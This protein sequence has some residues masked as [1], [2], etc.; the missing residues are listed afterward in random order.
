MA[1]QPRRIEPSAAYVKVRVSG[2]TH[3]VADAL[4][5]LHDAS[6]TEGFEIAE[7]S[8]PYPNRHDPG[9][10]VYLTLRFPPEGGPAAPRGSSSAITPATG[11]PA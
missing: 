3:G 5:V 8:R 7:E 6:E 9:Y 10:R 2:D 1:S 11:W 4:R